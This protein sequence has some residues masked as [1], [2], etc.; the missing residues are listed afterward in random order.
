MTWIKTIEYEEADRSLQRIYD[1]VK[2]PGGE[3]DNILKAHSLRPHTLYGHMALYKNV[4]HNTNNKL[5]KW[6][7]EAL[8]V[9]VSHLN[10]CL[11]CFDHHFVGMQRLLQNEERSEEIVETLLLSPPP[12]KRD[13][14]QVD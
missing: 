12:E 1:R 2:G 5:P 11:Y 14:A 7:L 9:Y 6:Y 10:Q 4:L 3:I 8:G 13:E